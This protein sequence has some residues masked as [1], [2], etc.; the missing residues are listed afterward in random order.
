M[1]EE[2][3]ESRK[4]LIDMLQGIDRQAD[5]QER[6]QRREKR[7]TEYQKELLEIQDRAYQSAVSIVVNKYQELLNNPD[8]TAKQ[9]EEL[10]QERKSFE[11][12]PSTKGVFREKCP[13]NDEGDRKRAA[14]IIEALK[15]TEKLG[16][17][18]EIDFNEMIKGFSER[19]RLS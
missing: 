13:I 6:K 8:L 17:P 14:E 5:Q 19:N 2:M 1:A 12:D 15:D 16:E 3:T 9:R 11:D 10:E 7:T 4:A 18:M